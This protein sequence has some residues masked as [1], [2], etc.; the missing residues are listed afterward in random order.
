MALTEKDVLA[1]LRDAGC[2]EALIQRFTAL[3]EHGGKETICTEQIRLLCGYRCGLMTELHAC[4]KKLDCL[5]YLLYAL[6]DEKKACCKKDDA[7]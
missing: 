6:R 2:D 5:D 3:E 1:A 7:K 4:Q